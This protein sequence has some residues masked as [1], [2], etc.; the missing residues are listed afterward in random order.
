MQFKR[1]IDPKE[2]LQIGKL[3]K[4]YR[5]AFIHVSIR[6]L[7]IPDN[8]TG[9]ERRITPNPQTVSRIRLA[10][11]DVHRMLQMMGEKE[12]FW[13]FIFELFPEQSQDI[14]NNNLSLAFFLAL[15]KER[16]PY[17]P[18]IEGNAFL[19]LRKCMGKDFLYEG[20]IYSVPETAK[21]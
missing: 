13:N 15:D 11:Q 21:L 3:W 17:H 20:K 18:S 9:S 16:E 19:S 5:V 7:S 1:G 6:D 10:G 4:S 2:S 12:T 14:K 8:R